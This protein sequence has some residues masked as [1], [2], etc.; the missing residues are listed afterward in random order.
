MTKSRNTGRTVTSNFSELIA[1]MDSGYF[2]R[3]VKF[4]SRKEGAIYLLTF[5]ATDNMTR[6]MKTSCTTT[7]KLKSQTGIDM[8][9]KLDHIT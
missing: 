2:L 4:T 6:W 9:Y 7:S 8:T 3:D 5:A 1:L